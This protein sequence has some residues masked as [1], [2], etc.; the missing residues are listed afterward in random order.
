MSR[1]VTHEEA[2]AALDAAALDALDVS[3][4]DAV[5]WHAAGCAICSAE[6]TSL[7]DT[8]AM[9]AF[10]SPLAADTATRSRGRIR[11]KLMERASKEHETN[12]LVDPP[13]T[14]R[15]AIERP[16]VPSRNIPQIVQPSDTQH[17]PPPSSAVPHVLFPTER[18]EFSRQ[19]RRFA[20]LRPE[21]MAIAATIVAVASMAGLAVTMRDRDNVEASLKE[22]TTLGAQARTI[23]DSLRAALM[24]RD[25]LIAGMTGKG[26]AMMTLT[27]TGTRTPMGHMFWD[28]TRNTWTL[29]AHDMPTLESG[30]AY[31]L[32]LVTSK[33]KISAGTFA[34]NTSGDAM[35]RSTYPLSAAELRAVAVTEE[36]AGGMP[37]PTGPMI[38]VAQAH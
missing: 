28:Q 11:S 12:E 36:P 35:M 27:S 5:L 20:W 2:F 18:P 31:Q 1:E 21:W 16:A 29:V 17:T 22:Q 9:L 26:V 34:S 7:R 3:E 14:E 15:P 24:S 23:T 4:R 33:G 30:R 10:S 32:W 13:A 38:M 8:A 25:S 6:L 19:E 37:Q